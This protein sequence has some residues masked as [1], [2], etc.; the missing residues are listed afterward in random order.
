MLPRGEDIREF[1]FKDLFSYD[2]L[3]FY[4]PEYCIVIQGHARTRWR[5]VFIIRP[6]MDSME[7][8]NMSRYSVFHLTPDGLDFIAV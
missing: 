3:N 6:E 8:V 5:L 2:F 1:F 4:F 7:S